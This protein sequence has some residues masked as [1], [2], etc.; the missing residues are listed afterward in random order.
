MR[1]YNTTALPP[2]YI[3]QPLDIWGGEAPIIS[4]SI[5]ITTPNYT[6]T[7]DS[8]KAGDTVILKGENLG[9]VDMSGLSETQANSITVKLSGSLSQFIPKD[10][11][12]VLK[13][14]GGGNN[15]ML[16]YNETF[17]FL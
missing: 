7:G 3:P 2:T 9:V 10:G 11:V 14:A 15:T 1:I 17:S 6:P 12:T 4:P 13:G 8:P 5:I 16:L